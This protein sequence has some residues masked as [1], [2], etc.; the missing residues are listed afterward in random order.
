M[1]VVTVANNARVCALSNRSRALRWRS[2][3][4]GSGMTTRDSARGEGVRGTC[5]IA[6]TVPAH[7]ITW[8]AAHQVA[9][10]LRDAC[11]RSVT[12]RG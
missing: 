7:V 10:T 11:L 9:P 5:P 12:D 4:G 8:P 3:G 6:F 2:L 1:A